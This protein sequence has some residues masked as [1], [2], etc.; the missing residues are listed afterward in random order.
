MKKI[1]FTLLVGILLLPPCEITAADSGHCENREV[2]NSNE[3]GDVVYALGSS[4]IKGCEGTACSYSVVL[5]SEDKGCS[6]RELRK[7][8][9]W[10]FQSYVSLSFIDAT[11]GW[12]LQY[13]DK[14][15]LTTDG[16]KKWKLLT[17]HMEGTYPLYPV[18][19][20][21]I[22][23]LDANRGWSVVNGGPGQAIFS[24]SDGG[25]TW[26]PVP[27][28]VVQNHLGFTEREYAEK[29][30]WREGDELLSSLPATKATEIKYNA[31]FDPNKASEA[32]QST[33]TPEK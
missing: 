32:P 19:F 33:S 18:V 12:V 25:K 28:N 5:K 14:L 23:F 16:G 30:R 15:F 21:S 27:F 24:S 22:Y 2:S 1:I 8:K 31:V 3:F 10:E 29:F 6:W 4:W 20:S 17:D 13:P 9:G 11:T 7:T 26:Q